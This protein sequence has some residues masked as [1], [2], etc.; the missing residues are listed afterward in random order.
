MMSDV[1]PDAA[2]MGCYTLVAMS[3]T[4]S[5]GL[6]AGGAALAG[7]AMAA[8]VATTSGPPPRG[9]LVG[10]PPP[11]MIREERPAPPAPHATWVTGYWHWTGIQYAWIPGHWEAAPPTGAVWR[12]PAYAQSNG[13]YFYEPGGWGPT[14]TRPTAPA[15]AEALH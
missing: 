5:A 15:A 6:L 11:A 4:R 13:A 7:L 9:I 1:V 3:G 14:P 10:G 2:Q 12:A 8:C